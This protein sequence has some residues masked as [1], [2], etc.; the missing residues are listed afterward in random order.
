MNQKE[1]DRLTLLAMLERDNHWHFPRARNIQLRLDNG[2]T[3]SAFDLSFI[4]YVL[5]TT[6]SSFPVIERNPD[7]HELTAKEVAFYNNL[8]QKA[9][10][11]EQARFAVDPHL[12][13]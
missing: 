4:H 5:E 2:E 10:E 1:Q 12:G 6:K 8:L 3:L 7:Y 13:I 9:I 11:N